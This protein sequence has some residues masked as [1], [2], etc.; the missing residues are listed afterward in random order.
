MIFITFSALI[1]IKIWLLNR[2]AWH[3][4]SL[5]CQWFS[6]IIRLYAC[7]VVRMNELL[8]YAKYACV[9][10]WTLITVLYN[11]KISMLVFIVT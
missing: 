8:H 7:V 11:I 5:S 9:C 2:K 1:I 6:Y 3:F 10:N 4:S